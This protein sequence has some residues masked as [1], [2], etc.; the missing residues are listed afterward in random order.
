MG[1]EGGGGSHQ[2]DHKAVATTDPKLFILHFFLNHLPVNAICAAC[3]VSPREQ[4]NPS[5]VYFFSWSKN[6][7]KKIKMH[8]Q[9]LLSKTVEITPS[10]FFWRVAVLFQ[11]SET[12]ERK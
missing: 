11:G 5:F 12:Y 9:L 2:N 7:S 4:T 8:L 6:V 1:G 3:W 10:F